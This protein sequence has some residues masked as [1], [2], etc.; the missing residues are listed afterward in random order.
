MYKGQIEAGQRIIKELR[1]IKVRYAQPI[2][3][4]PKSMLNFQISTFN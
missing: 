2:V 1:A 4:F 3:D